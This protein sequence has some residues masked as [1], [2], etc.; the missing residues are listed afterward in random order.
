MSYQWQKDAV[1]KALNIRKVHGKPVIQ[2]GVVVDADC[3]NIAEYTHRLAL[4][5]KQ[6]RDMCHEKS[7]EIKRILEAKT[8]KEWE[9]SREN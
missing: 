9:E 2:L 4:I 7:L 8:K 1:R 5:E 3:A 6:V